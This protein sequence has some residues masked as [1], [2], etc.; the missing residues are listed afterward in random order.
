MKKLESF[1]ISVGMTAV[2]G[3]FVLAIMALVQLIAVPF[4]SP[5]AEISTAQIT[6]T[7]AA[8]PADVSAAED[9]A[10]AASSDASNAPDP[11]PV[12]AAIS[13]EAGEAVF[14]K[15]KACHTVDEGGRNGAGPNLFG[16]VG[17]KVAA[18]EGFAYSEALLGHAEEAWTPEFLSTYLEDPRKAIPGNKMSFGGLRKEEDRHNLIAFL[19]SQSATPMTPAELGF[20]AAVATGAGVAASDTDADTAT[21]EV[22]IDP[23]PW[24]E[25]VTYRDPEPRSAQEQA[26]V[27]ARVAALQ[28][29][30]DAG[31]DYER[32]RYHPLHFPPASQEA[33]NE[34]CLVCHQEI[35]DHTPR[36]ESPAGVK[37]DDTL[38]WYQTLDT[39][40]G[41]QASF[42]YRHLES[43]Y[44]KM[45]MNLECS[46]C[47][48]GNDVREES[49]D[50]MRSREPFMAEATPEF[51]LRKM[52]N[53]SETC[54]LCHGEMPDAE[55]I[56]GLTGPWHEVREDMEWPEAPNGCL[57]CHAESFRTV[58]HNVSYLK[59]LSI[60][61]LA[62]LGSSDTCYGCHGGR[63]WYRISYPYPRHDWP[64]MFDDETP[65]WAVDRPK[66]SL[67]EYLMS[68]PQTDAE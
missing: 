25:G 41:D 21:A 27:E 31:L 39:Y 32:A 43:D 47:H 15:C 67:S 11:T 52:V 46:F 50:M 4:K 36:D 16:I 35:M 18:V 54:L 66:E 23:V 14:R 17:Q 1:M 68:I 49:P 9:Q 56:M 65:A 51:T 10:P 13:A 57:S 20:A 53:P 42:H 63:D 62:R 44:A 34:E 45:V 33:S 22:E 24:P 2:L 30:V 38:A 26:E 64:G 55:T 29:E 58:R 3:T 48:K 5:A 19:A 61:E 12:V 59:A 8:A 40:M 6:P 60:E 7:P 28:A 37:T